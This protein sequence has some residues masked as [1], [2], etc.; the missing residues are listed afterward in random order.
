VS[1][2]RVARTTRRAGAVHAQA[3]R[4]GARA[5]GWYETV[6]VMDEV[7]AC[8]ERANER[9]VVLADW[10]QSGFLAGMGK[11]RVVGSGYWSNL[12][13]LNASHELFSTDSEQRFWE[14]VTERR[15]EYFFRPPLPVLEG[16]IRNSFRVRGRGTPT[17]EQV[18]QTVIWGIASS[19]NWPAVTCP[20]LARLAPACSV[21]RLDRPAGLTPR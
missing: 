5:T 3:R 4:L 21:L 18:E 19:A 11:V 17:I 13:G 1:R 9:P 8:L 12:Q 10:S 16:A 14:L 20:R 2:G 15:I 7:S 6:L